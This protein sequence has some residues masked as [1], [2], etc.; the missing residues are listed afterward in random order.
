MMA[1]NLDD[2]GQ[3]VDPIKVSSFLSDFMH[4]CWPG[5]T[6]SCAVLVLHCPTGAMAD[7][8][9]VHNTSWVVAQPP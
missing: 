3:L 2:Q 7:R 4:E 5:G 1:I 8:R 6:Q 9:D